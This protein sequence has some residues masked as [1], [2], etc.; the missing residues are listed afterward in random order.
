MKLDGQAESTFELREVTVDGAR[1]RYVDVGQ[2]DPLVLLHGWPESHAAWR[3]QIGPLALSRRVIAPDWL[4]WGA[5]DRDTNL[6]CDYD[7]EVERIGRMLD[8]LGLERVDLACHDYGGFL[9]L[10]FL[11]RHPERVRRF[12]I[13]NS[14]GQGIF[15]PPYY[16]LFGL[17]TVLARTALLRPLVTARA[18]QW[19]HRVGLAPY[20]RNGSFDSQQLR[21]Y[22]AVLDTGAGR[23]WNAHFWS[24]YRVRIRPELAAG[25]GAISCPTTVIWGDRDPAI[26]FRTARELAEAIPYA[27][28]VRIDGGNHFIMEERPDEVTEALRA[29]LLRPATRTAVSG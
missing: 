2:G 11:Q 17:L 15:T 6:S 9:G 8:A 20:V 28:L 5:S 12:A 18:I 22:L 3:H 13:L 24:G 7:S 1:L 21:R 23:R 27:T 10:G 29:W 14:R 19:V 16:V 26:P 4:G 25:L